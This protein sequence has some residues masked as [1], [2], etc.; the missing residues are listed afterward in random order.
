MCVKLSPRDLNPDPYPLHFTNIY[1]Y[2]V[3]TISKVCGDGSGFLCLEV[4]NDESSI[5]LLNY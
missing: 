5:Q 4:Y 1:T 3:T 2:K